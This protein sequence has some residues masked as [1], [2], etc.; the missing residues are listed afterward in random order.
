MKNPQ[1]CGL[2][3]HDRF[4]DPANVIFEFAIRG[5]NLF[6]ICEL[7]TSAIPQIHTFSP[8]KYSV[9]YTISNL[10]II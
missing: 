7:K 8:Y 4:A 3:F 2:K 9:K 6:V 10:Y 1:I 5:H